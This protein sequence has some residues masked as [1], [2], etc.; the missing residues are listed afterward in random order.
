MC[1]GLSDSCAD[2]TAQPTA[3]VEWLSYALE[4]VT[5]HLKNSF[6]QLSNIIDP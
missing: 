3:N 1:S 2:L 5:S 6:V 4:A